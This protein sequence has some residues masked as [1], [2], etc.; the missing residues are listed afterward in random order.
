MPPSGQAGVAEVSSSERSVPVNRS[1]SAR[2][3]RLVI[4]PEVTIVAFRRPDAV[5]S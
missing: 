5:N 1:Y 3:M 4:A 2:S